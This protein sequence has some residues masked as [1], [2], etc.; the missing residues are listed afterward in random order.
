MRPRDTRRPPTCRQAARRACR[1]GKPSRGAC[2]LHTARRSRSAV[3]T[4]T[5]CRKGGPTA[6][7]CGAAARPRVG[8]GAAGGGCAQCAR[9]VRAQRAWPRQLARVPRGEVPWTPMA[10]WGAAHLGDRGL[11]EN[12]DDETDDLEAAE[13]PAARAVQQDVSR[14][15]GPARCAKIANVGQHRQRRR[16]MPRVPQPRST[17]R[18][19]GRARWPAL[20]AAGALSVRDLCALSD[21]CHGHS[22]ACWHGIGVPQGPMG[23]LARHSGGLIPIGAP[24]VRVST[25][26]EPARGVVPHSVRW[27]F[28]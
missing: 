6:E 15:L 26:P 23:R 5:T 4:G 13:P 17:G 11:D 8:A 27:I 1:P 22:P 25:P 7:D 16:G 20:P 9:H 14:R 28:I 18:L 21:R 12:A 10:A 19:H 24:L 2:G 3:S